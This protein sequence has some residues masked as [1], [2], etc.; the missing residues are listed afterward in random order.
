MHRNTPQVQEF[1]AGGK[2]GGVRARAP[3]INNLQQ[4][5][6]TGKN[7]PASTGMKFMRHERVIAG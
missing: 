2:E 1:W 5:G 4:T 7:R 3:A 6:A